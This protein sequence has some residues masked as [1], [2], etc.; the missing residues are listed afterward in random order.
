MTASEFEILRADLLMLRNDV[1][2]HF[3]EMEAKLDAKPSIA[4]L[5]Q[6]VVTLMFGIEAVVI[7]EKHRPDGLAR[8]FGKRAEEPQ[9]SEKS[10]EALKV[11]DLQRGSYGLLRHRRQDELGHFPSVVR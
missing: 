9:E 2:R 8:Q 5:Y 3:T 7:F 11:S 10:L 6:T 1:D 4:T